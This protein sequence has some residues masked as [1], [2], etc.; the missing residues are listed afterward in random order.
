MLIHSVGRNTIQ[1]GTSLARLLVIVST[2]LVILMASTM[3]LMTLDLVLLNDQ[4][5][6]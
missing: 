6:S 2:P 5:D 3:V 4:R 1:L